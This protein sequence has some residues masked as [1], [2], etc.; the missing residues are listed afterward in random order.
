[1]KFILVQTGVHR[2]SFSGVWL[3]A[4]KV[5]SNISSITTP[6]LLNLQYPSRQCLLIITIQFNLVNGQCLILPD[7]TSICNNILAQLEPACMRVGIL[8]GGGQ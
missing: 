4:M 6:L 8:Q 2:E 7:A 1:M 5:Y 3:N